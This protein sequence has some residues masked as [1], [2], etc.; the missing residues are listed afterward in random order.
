MTHK[1]NKH[2][3]IG[4]FVRGLAM[5]AADVVPGVSGGTVA[6]MTGI[7][8]RLVGA[9]AS[10]DMN[11][12]RAILQLKIAAVW[13]QVD[14]RFLLAVLLGIATAVFSLANIMAYLLATY[15]VLLWSL[16]FGLILAAAILMLFEL[17]K[18]GLLELTAIFFG[19]GLSFFIT[20][21]TP[22]IADPALWYLFVC[23]AVAIC[24]MLLPGIS[25][26]F[27][28]L[29]MG[30]Y[31]I[32]ITAI[33]EL[34][35]AKLVAVALGCAV[36]ILSFAKILNWLML[37][38]KH[39]VMAMMCGFLLGSLALVWPWRIPTGLDDQTAGVLPATYAVESGMEPQVLACV[40]L[41]LLGMSLVAFLSFSGKRSES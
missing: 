1:N 40:G 9:L 28:L 32:V 29:L 11:L 19:T 16:F 25:G 5:G 23:G 6:L 3:D 14:G 36:G 24:A 13:E 26:S 38:H 22:A 21:Q 2:S 4:L 20:Q 39:T 27:I 12:V 35:I 34:D 8:E 41:V 37:N 17:K 7:Y 30:A 10:I 33:S 15:P 18:V 31:P